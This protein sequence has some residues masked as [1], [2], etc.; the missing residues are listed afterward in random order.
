M[1]ITGFIH[2]SLCNNNRSKEMIL[3]TWSFLILIIIFFRQSYFSWDCIRPDGLNHSLQSKKP[4]IVRADFPRVRIIHWKKYI[5]I[6]CYEISNVV[7]KLLD[8]SFSR[9]IEHSFD[10]PWWSF[11]PFFLFKIRWSLYINLFCWTLRKQ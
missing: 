4:M 8:R 11:H 3:K 1:E 2:G 6:K 7:I 10:I 9:Q 5:W